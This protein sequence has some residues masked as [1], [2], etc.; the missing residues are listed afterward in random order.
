MSDL[1]P[2]YLE[3]LT[4]RDARWF[5]FDLSLELRA[6]LEQ[7][8][9]LAILMSKLRADAEDA[10]QEFANANC[11]DTVLIQGLQSR[12]F[13]LMVARETFNAILAAGAAAEQ[14]IVA[15]DQAE[16]LAERERY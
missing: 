3:A 2:E 5:K 10:M 14:E 11:G 4:Q 1:P 12:V 6:A 15:E 9:P 7:S 8:R 13:R 16:A